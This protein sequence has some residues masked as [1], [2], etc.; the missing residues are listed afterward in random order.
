[1]RR[2]FQHF[3][4]FI[5]SGN[6]VGDAPVMSEE[7]LAAPILDEEIEIPTNDSGQTKLNSEKANSEKKICI[8]L[9][10][11]TPLQAK[12]LFSNVIKYLT[13]T[14]ILHE[15]QEGE[16][17]GKIKKFRD[18]PYDY[19]FE[20]GNIIINTS[21][22]GIEVFHQYKA[23]NAENPDSISI[24]LTD[25]EMSKKTVE[26]D[27]A[28][29]EKQNA[30]NAIDNEN[31]LVLISN[32]HHHHSSVAEASRNQ[33]YSMILTANDFR[34]FDKKLLPDHQMLTVVSG[35]GKNATLVLTDERGDAKTV[36]CLGSKNNPTPSIVEYLND[37]FGHA[38]NLVDASVRASTFS[39]NSVVGSVSST[40]RL[41]PSL[42]E[43]SKISPS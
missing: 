1:M 7:T 8:F 5:T 31:G 6:K 36:G 33:L 23:F 14:N 25:Y 22:D 21:K 43:H 41:L 9:A 15:E 16:I 29:E 32:V 12:L 34:D 28:E 30:Q 40:T 37:T 17:A 24:V 42:A 13:K 11:D 39:T 35:E 10:D 26:H 19:R 3:L 27:I 4:N 20:H 18:A 2:F 38:L